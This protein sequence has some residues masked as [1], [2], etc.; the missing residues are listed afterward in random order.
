MKLPQAQ[1]INLSSGLRL[2]HLWY[3]GAGAGIFGMTVKAG[4]ADES[5]GNF[6]LAHLVEHT[7]FKGTARRRPYHIINRM[8]AVGGE[9]NAFTTKEDTTVYTIFPQG[10]AARA[11]ELVADLAINSQFPQAEI[12]KER[13]VVI[14]EINSYRDTPSEAVYDDFED[15][16]YAGT[17]DRKS[18]V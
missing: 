18:V 17:P 12:E 14:D 13:E 3:H 10:N 8:E 1:V 4:S 15:M 9:L 2:V 16:V 11:I 5:D 7:I 6:G